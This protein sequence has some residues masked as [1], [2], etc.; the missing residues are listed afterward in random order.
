MRG[1]DDAAAVVQVRGGGDEVAAAD[2]RGHGGCAGIEC[3]P[4]AADACREVEP[5]HTD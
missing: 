3:H 5:G 4:A 2:L 1:R